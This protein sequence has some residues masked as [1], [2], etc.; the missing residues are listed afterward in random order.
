MAGDVVFQ[1][2]DN[3]WYITGRQDNYITLYS[4]PARMVSDMFKMIFRFDFEQL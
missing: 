1:Y 2:I 3:L 4:I